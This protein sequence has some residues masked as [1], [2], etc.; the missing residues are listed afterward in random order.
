MRE[1]WERLGRS[2]QVI[3]AAA[4]IGTLAALIGFIAWAGTPQYVPLFSN[5]SAQD[6]NA[7]TQKLNDANVPNKLT[8]GG[9][10]VEVPAQL[11]DEWQM[12]LLSENL[13]SQSSSSVNGTDDILNS[14]HMGDSQNIED[15]RIR[16]SREDRIESTI[17]KIDDIAAAVV[18]YAPSDDSPLLV[19]HHESSVS[20]LLTLK[21]G[22][23]LSDENVH[24]IV[25]LVQMSFTGLSDK[26]ISVVDSDGNLL[27]DGLHSS[28]AQGD[29]MQKQ[30][31]EQQ[32]QEQASLQTA[33]DRAIGPHRSIVLV[34]EELNNDKIQRHVVTALQGVPTAKYD[35]TEKLTGQGTAGSRPQVGAA[36]NIASAN[37]PVGTPTYVAATSGPNGNYSHEDTTTTYQTGTSATDTTVGDGQVKRLDVSVLLD[38]G[39]ISSSQ[40]QPAIA[41]I[42]QMVQTAIGYDPNDLTHSRQVS[43]S[44]ISFDHSQELS[45]NRAASAAASAESMRRVLAVLVPFLIMAAAI[46]L[47]AR[48]LRRTLPQPLSSPRLALAGGGSMEDGGLGLGAGQQENGIEGGPEG[49]LALSS[50]NAPRTFEVIEEAFDSNLESI[51]HLARS[52][53]EMLA[54]LV[55]SWLA[56]EN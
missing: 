1:W 41:T 28:D 24:A 15:L 52:K 12:K 21:P 8:Q 36:G 47:L 22:H 34:H 6:A 11:H 29:A 55:K 39:K 44:A 38:S 49:P 20:V 10:A 9:T 32:R 35:E 33:L 13:P 46:A 54:M 27:W 3:F 18:H 53:P 4:S 40:L 5:L 30:T 26:H 45:A 37:S 2:N 19:D 51:L 42:T 31:L 17:A 7:I 23:Q 56:D 14:A 25:R 43:V 16:R 50:H 48:S